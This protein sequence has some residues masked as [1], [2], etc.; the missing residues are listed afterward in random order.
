[1]NDFTPEDRGNAFSGG[2]V[3]SESFAYQQHRANAKV[4]RQF[5]PHGVNQQVAF[6]GVGMSARDMARLTIGATPISGSLPTSNGSSALTNEQRRPF[7]S[8]YVSASY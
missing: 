7:Q 6:S 1:M 2:T 3:P 5:T 8:R 4:P